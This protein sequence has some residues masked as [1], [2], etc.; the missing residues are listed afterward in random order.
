MPGAGHRVSDAVTA[1]GAALLRLSC[2]WWL[3]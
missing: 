3:K 1:D 2:V